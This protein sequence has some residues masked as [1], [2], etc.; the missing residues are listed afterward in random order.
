MPETTM[1]DVMRFFAPVD[2]KEF[3]DFWAGLSDEEK[4]D[5][6]RQVAEA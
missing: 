3:K 2:L 4:E 1:M 6:K 5:F